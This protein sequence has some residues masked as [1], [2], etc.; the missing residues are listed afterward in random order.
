[1][2][3]VRASGKDAA[4]R[5]FTA[6]G[7]AFHQGQLYIYAY[8]FKGTVIAHGGDKTLVGK[9][10]IDMKDP[11]GVPVIRELVRLAKTGSGW[12]HFTWGN[13][14]NGNKQEPKLGYVE[15]VDDTWFLGSGTYGPA[16]TQP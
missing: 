2:E 13:P 11:N 12:L 16:A 8:D 1:M 3:Y 15:K 6:P 14:A 10:L 4:L 9:N 5:T 7:G